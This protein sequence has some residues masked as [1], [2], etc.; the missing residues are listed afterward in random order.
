[1]HFRECETTHQWYRSHKKLLSVTDTLIDLNPTKD[2]TFRVILVTFR[3]GERAHPVLQRE[4]HVC[5]ILVECLA[6]WG[7]RERTP[8]VILSQRGVCVYSAC[9]KITV[10][11]LE[12]VSYCNVVA[13]HRQQ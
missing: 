1:M 6:L 8:P 9:D 3:F 5:I 4:R 11:V 7:E 13:V 12:E 2:S 10:V